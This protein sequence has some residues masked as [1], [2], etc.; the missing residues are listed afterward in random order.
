[1]TTL[2]AVGKDFSSTP[3]TD[4][5]IEVYAEAMADMFLAYLRGQGAS[6]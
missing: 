3:R 5:E 2:T 6:G 4:G 1:M